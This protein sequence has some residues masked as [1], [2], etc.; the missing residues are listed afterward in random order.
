MSKNNASDQICLLLT[1]TFELGLCSRL[2]PSLSWNATNKLS[3]VID[4]LDLQ[5]DQDVGW[6][7]RAA[8]HNE[9]GMHVRTCQYNPLLMSLN[10]NRVLKLL[11]LHSTKGSSLHFAAVLPL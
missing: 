3:D 1:Y 10:F 4:L 2:T 5:I 6:I 7:G 8:K 9:L 11:T